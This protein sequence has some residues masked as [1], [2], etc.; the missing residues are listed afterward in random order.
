MYVDIGRYRRK[1]MRSMDRWE[2]G[3]ILL[4]F[5]YVHY[6]YITTRCTTTTTTTTL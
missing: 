5:L 6:K 1:D 4:A 2:G 3:G